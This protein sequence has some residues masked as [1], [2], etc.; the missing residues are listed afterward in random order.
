MFRAFFDESGTNPLE[1]KALV[2]GGFLARVE[3][4]ER[5][6]DAWDACLHDKPSIEYFK[7]SEAQ[8]L[9]GEFRQFNRTS[10]DAKVLAL[11]KTINRFPNLRGFGISV[12]HRLF[13]HRDAKATQGMVGTRVYD[14][15]FLTATSGLLQYLDDEHPGDEKI[16][17]VFDECSQLNACI[18]HYN[19]MKT[20]EPFLTDIMRRAG[21]CS[22]GNDKE[23]A[24]LQMGDLLAREFSNVGE[25]KLRSEAFNLI[26]ENNMIVHIPCQPP[27]QMPNTLALQK[28]ANQVS[29]EAGNFFRRGKKGSP[30]RF[31]SA[32][33]VE[34]YTNEL[35]IHEAYFQL[36]WKR[37]QSQLDTD[38]AY[39][40][41]MKKYLEAGK[42][43]GDAE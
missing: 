20:T 33:E 13:A 38:E 30:D 21:Q 28:I 10:A 2:M 24:A 25:T 7:H 34:E 16:D 32:Q 8:S 3:E 22:P 1:N 29:L 17:F 5:A 14:W 19:W 36:E 37:Y 39:Q 42:K 18:E 6:S 35:K 12:P 40:E 9:G 31:T 27:R 41:F 23:I 4:W 43:A 26:A 15:G 11:T